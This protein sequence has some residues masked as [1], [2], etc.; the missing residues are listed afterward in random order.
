MRIYAIG[1]N[2]SRA[3]ETIQA[4]APGAYPG[5]KSDGPAD[6][7]DG[8]GRP[9]TIKVHYKDGAADVPDELGRL[10]LAQKLAKRTRLLLPGLIGLG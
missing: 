6:W 1:D 4:V 2:A 5:A 3:A 7:F 10:M 8:E 9:V